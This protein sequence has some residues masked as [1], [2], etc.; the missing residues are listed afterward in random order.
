MYIL[1]LLNNWMLSWHRLVNSNCF[2]LMVSS[3]FFKGFQDIMQLN[4]CLKVRWT[5][6]NVPLIN[7]FAWEML[8]YYFI[9]LLYKKEKYIH[10]SLF[11]IFSFKYLPHIHLFHLTFILKYMPIIY[12]S[13]INVK[14]LF[15]IIIL[16]NY[17]I[18]Y[19]H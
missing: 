2:N 9:L 16:V 8:N 1:V 12:K 6:L 3:V 10:L 17:T 18:K 13:H 5:M 15:N 7:V 19:F 14:L 4:T 11:E